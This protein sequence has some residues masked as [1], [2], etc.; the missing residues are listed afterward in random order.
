MVYRTATPEDRNELLRLWREA[1]SEDG[2]WFF[3]SIDAQGWCADDGEGLRAMAFALPQTLVTAKGAYP[4]AYIYAVTTQREFRG[5]GVATALFQTMENALRDQG[6]WGA[7]LVPATPGLFRLYEKMGYRIWASRPAGAAETLGQPCPAETYLALRQA[8]LPLPAVQPDETVLWQYRLYRFDGGVYATDA[9]GRVVERLPAS[10][11]TGGPF[12][13]AK[14]LRE[15]FPGHGY[16][17]FA[18]E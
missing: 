18:M 5:R 8:Y 12:A 1:F 14:A 15:G 10:G 16:F 17:A 9:A 4:V 2:E 7:I 6:V 13:A 11:Q 3:R